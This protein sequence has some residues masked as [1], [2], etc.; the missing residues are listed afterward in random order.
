MKQIISL[1][2]LLFVFVYGI[3][4]QETDTTETKPWK[5][6]TVF[7]TTLAQTSL[8]N[9]AG[10]GENSLSLSG[11][12]NTTANYA[13]KKISWEN[14]FDFA[15][16]L[17]KQGDASV[18]K[19]DDKIEISSKLGRQIKA[20]WNLTGDVEFRSQFSPG[21]ENGILISKFLAP[22]YIVST[23]GLEY[24]P[25]EEFY[26]LIS[27]L[28]DKTT[29]VMDDKLSDAGAYG[30]DPGDKIRNELGSYLKS[31]LKVD[32]MENI[33]LQTKLNLF[34]AYEK[35]LDQTDVSWETLLLMRV[36][37]YITTNFNTHLIYDEDVTTDVQFKEVLSVGVIFE[38]K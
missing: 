29:L 23:I 25:H 3:N 15:Y 16:G 35:N 34:S 38:L 21:Y 28:T 30:V 24:K 17:I 6:G 31:M 7:N 36:N 8:S 5:I 18:E 32:L 20:H 9:W 4:A 10:G 2:F 1:V 37:K 33:S 27:P 13:K 11:L 19:S 22:A 26:V 14:S 12:S